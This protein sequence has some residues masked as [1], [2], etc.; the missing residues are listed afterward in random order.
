MKLIDIYK[1]MKELHQDH[2]FYKRRKELEVKKEYFEKRVKEIMD[3][4]ENIKKEEGVFINNLKEEIKQ[5]EITFKEYI[6]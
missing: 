2:I 1:S 4:I 5:F 3:A 6:K